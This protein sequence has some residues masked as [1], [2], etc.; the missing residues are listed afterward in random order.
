[1]SGVVWA[2]IAGILFGV[3]QAVNRQTLV[4]LDVVAS[5]FIQLLVSSAVMIA[6]LFVQGTD[7]IGELSVLSV[8]NFTLA[9]LIHFLG[10]WTLL[11]ISQKRLGAARTSP[12][13]A[14][15]PL[16]GTVLG[17]AVFGEIPARSRSP[18]SR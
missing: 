15:T 2:A 12:L 4:R 17:I 16:F 6:A 7:A 9:G 3:F 5:T 13:L 10:G 1:M 18:G 14:A 8:T 11:N